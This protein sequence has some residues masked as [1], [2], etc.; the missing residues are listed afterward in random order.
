MKNRI[1]IA[2]FLAFFAKKITAQVGINATNTPPNTS[3]MLDISSTTK[4]LLIPRMTTA[5]KDAIPNK[6][7]GLTVYDIDL[8]Q[9]SYW[10]IENLIGSW[11]NFGGPVSGA[12]GVGWQAN[13]THIENTNTG[14]V[15]IGVL[16][17]TAKLTIAGTDQNG[18][19]AISGSLNTSH[20]NY[21]ISG[22]ENTYIRG[23]SNGSHVLLNDSQGLG[24]VGIGTAN[25][26]TKLDV[27]GEGRF[28]SAFPIT[29]NNQLDYYSGGG[30]S[31]F[32]NTNNGI[33]IDSDKAQS[34]KP[35]PGFGGG[36]TVNNFKINPFGGNVGIGTN[37]TPE[38][39]LHIWNNDDQLIKID[40]ENS[41]VA[42][43]DNQTNAQYG[44]MRA[45]TENPFNPAALYGLEIGVP[46]IVG[47]DPAKHLMFST[48]YNLRMVIRDNGNIGIGI[49][50]PGIYKLAVNGS[51]R[52]KE[53]VVEAINWP[54]Y[55]FTKDYKLKSIGELEQFI[56]K[57]HHLPN[58]A[59]A[60]EIEKS[61]LKVGEN[62][63]FMMEK[64]EE[65]TLYI[66]QLKKE[67]DLI[68]IK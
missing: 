60:A 53:L 26:F 13:G 10:K 54:D 44:F 9:F 64:I 58:I 4:G 61:G 32:D 18:T 38:Y 56:A 6:S 42:F 59:N 24:N 31:V 55:V 50:D 12:S 36:Q 52:S 68:K 8:K 46:P 34:V 16:N 49:N 67:I 25:P 19:L 63:K 29:Y 2:L 23:G 27:A 37:F 17:P 33:L 35:E 57:N 5:Q 48:N 14:N 62:Q 1:F 3:A 28:L 47:V 11:Q 22:L 21:P 65:L 40:G 51:I 41:V 43:H 39:K 66:I 7:E 30:L 20:F 45:W 15:G